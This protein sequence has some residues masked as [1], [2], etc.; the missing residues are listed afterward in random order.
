M[1]LAAAYDLE[2]LQLDALNVFLNSD[3]DEDIVVDYL[4][5]FYKRDK[6]LKLKKALYGLK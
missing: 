5:R 4:P 6:V 3:I 1:A 2:I